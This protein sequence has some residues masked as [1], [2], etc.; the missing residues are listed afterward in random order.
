MTTT[1]IVVAG[2]GARGAYEAGVLSVLVPRLLEDRD[3][4]IVLI[5]TSAGAINTAILAAFETA[6]EAVGEMTR[7]WTSVDAGDVFSSI[8]ASSPRTVFSFLR[9]RLD[10]VLDSRPLGAT[11][12]A[13][14]DW[15][16]LDRNLRGS[17]WVDTAGIVA[18]SCATGRCVAFVQGS[19]LVLP[20]PDEPAGIDYVS[21]TLGSAHVM[22]SAAI[23]VA[24]RPVHIDEP[25]GRRGWYL[26]GGVKLNAPIKPA[27][28]LGADRVVVVATTPD[29]AGPHSS[30]VSAGEPDIF[31]AGA[32]VMHAFLVDRMADDIRALRR[33]NTLISGGDRASGG[34]RIVPNLYLGP[35]E[36]GLI[37]D[38]A[39][40]V[41]TRRYAGIRRPFSDLGL[42]GRLLGGT[43]ESHGQ[44]LSFMF[45]DREFH[46]AL[47][48]L[49]RAH[50]SDALGRSGS[51][52]PWDAPAALTDAASV[53]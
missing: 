8:V 49:G 51:P 46:E 23:P 39:N 53:F 43:R 47:I 2:A 24:F 32:V 20:A 17:G 45:F 31:D 3:D 14:L 35:P 7:L 5:G 33:V 11:M 50:A 15:Q 44:L 48:E 52:F 4:R 26:D 42:V 12:E 40:D 1:A 19:D 16:Q 34:F 27:I 13:R 36:P 38:T 18:T 9:R 10:S 29:P 30:P 22:A 6:E 21:T 37:G 25:K 41:F 28:A